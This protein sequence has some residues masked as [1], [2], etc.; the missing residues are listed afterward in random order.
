MPPEI[1][2]GQRDE[3]GECA[4]AVH[5]DALRVRAQV[6]PPRQQVDGHV[7]AFNAI[8]ALPTRNFQAATFDGTAELAEQTAGNVAGDVQGMRRVARSSCASCTI[9]C[10][11]IYRSRG[12]MQA[13]IEAAKIATAAGTHL[14]IGSGRVDPLPLVSHRLPL[15]ETGEALALQRGGE[16]LK[17]VVVP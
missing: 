5:A 16:A 17:V 1:G 9:G 14:V 11:H 13:K 3:F 7:D 12:G 10:E 6:P 2:H 4:G 8:N 15:T